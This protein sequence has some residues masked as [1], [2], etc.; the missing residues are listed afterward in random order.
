MLESLIVAFAAL[1]M[2]DPPRRSTRLGEKNI[3]DELTPDINALDLAS[4]RRAAEQ[5]ARPAQPADAALGTLA[6]PIPP[7]SVL[8][9]DPLTTTTQAEV[10][11][12]GAGIMGSWTAWHLAKR[13]VRRL[14]RRQASGI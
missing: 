4:N 2:S 13:G 3:M 14:V 7:A 6:N 5:V 8:P 9:A 11:V 1:V 10:V 12:V